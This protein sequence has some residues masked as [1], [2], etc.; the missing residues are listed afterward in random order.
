MQTQEFANGID[1]L[2]ELA[3]NGQVAIMCAE[4]LPWRCHRWLIADALTIRGIPVEH[5]MT[6]K[7]RTKHSLT[8]WASIE[9]T[10][11]TYP[12]SHA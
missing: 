11:I 5:I 4:I 7:K 8:K 9:D 3:Q 10:Q 2:I 1:Q 6:T 12:E